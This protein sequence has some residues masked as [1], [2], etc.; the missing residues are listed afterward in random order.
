MLRKSHFHALAAASIAATA[1]LCLP[2]VAQNSAQMP[3]QPAAADAQQPNQPNIQPGLPLGITARSMNTQ[4]IE[5]PFENATDAVF[6]ADFNKIVD[7]LVDQD[8]D[9]ISKGD[10]YGDSDP[11]IQ[12]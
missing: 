10:K 7:Q 9:R 2:T 11:L 8:R 1:Y 5:S 3:A 12:K 4:S 6:A